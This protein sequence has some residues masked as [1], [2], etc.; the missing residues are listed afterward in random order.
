MKSSRA[1]VLLFVNK[2]L[3]WFVDIFSPI[4]FSICRYQSLKKIS[5][6]FSIRF[7]N[8]LKYRWRIIFYLQFLSC[9][10][11]NHFDCI[12]AYTA[13]Y[14]LTMCVDHCFCTVAGILSSFIIVSKIVRKIQNAIFIKK[15]LKK[16]SDNL[17]T[18]T[19][20]FLFFE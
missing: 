6:C 16:S 20:Y 5:L 8:R 7:R 4:L 13:L 2:R 1:C 3:F 11:L 14:R 17:R 10:Q 9:N 12:F 18:R 19:S 15:L